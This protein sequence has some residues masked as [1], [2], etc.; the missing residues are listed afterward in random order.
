MAGKRE[1][2]FDGH[3]PGPVELGSGQLAQPC[4]ELRRGHP[5]SPHDRARRN[6]LGVAGIV[7][8]AHRL[9][10][11][12]DDG[13]AQHRRDAKTLQR[14]L[15]LGRQRWREGCEHPVGRLDQKDAAGPRVD[16]VEV[17]PERV[18]R[19]L[20]DLAGHLDARGS[21]A[22]DGE[23]QPGGAA[24][25]VGLRLGR[26][27]RAENSAPHRQRALERLDLGRELAPVVV[28]KVGIARAAG[29]DQGVVLHRGGRRNVGNRAQVN[30]ARIEIEVG[31][32]RQQHADVAV[33][34]EDRPQRIGDLARRQRTGRHLVGER[35]EQV[36]VSPVDQ[37]HLDW[38]VAKLQGSLKA[39]EAPTDHD[40]TMDAGIAHARQT[41]P[42]APRAVGPQAGVV[43]CGARAVGPGL[44]S[45]RRCPV[46]G[47]RGRTRAEISPALSGAGS[48]PAC[49]RARRRRVADWTGSA[50]GGGGRGCE[51]GPGR[52]RGAED[53]R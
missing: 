38:V 22:D 29:D 8:D 37:R 51:L 47:A 16:R 30:R 42:G 2:G 1:V 26:L 18:A 7:R 4:P 13:R 41:V 28:A 48:A 14:P 20:G 21:G 10:V 6:A 3:A 12:P 27:E 40:H 9:G 25:R 53:L 11:D 31:D 50:W 34:L 43:P 24:L 15:R 32:L 5:G 23:R 33:A 49:A 44:R 46:R 52:R 45:V 19:Q 36:E 39:T 35:L 17:E